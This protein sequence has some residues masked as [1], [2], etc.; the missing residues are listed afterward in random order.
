L[1]RALKLYSSI[2]LNN[3]VLFDATGKIQRYE[4]ALDIIKD[5]AKLRLGVYDKRKNYLVAKL[6]RECE[7]LSAKA[8]FIKLVITGQLII[9]R[10]KILDLVADLRKRGFKPLEDVKGDEAKPDGDN[11]ESDK[12]E[13]DDGEEAEDA[14]DQEQNK[15]KQ[16]AKGIKDFE[17]L[18]G[19][20][21]STLTAEKIE[22]LMRQHDL[23]QAELDALRKKKI[24]RLW[25][26]D[27]DELEQALE[28]REASILEQQRIE[29]ARLA[30][31][32]AKAKTEKEPKRG[33]KRT[34]SNPSAP[35]AKP[36]TEEGTARGQKR[37]Q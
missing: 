30:K 27:L 36:R 2:S 12:E 19:M 4:S 26:D 5:F 6:M 22:E 17:Y 28:E 14:D 35:S 8:R 20:P 13:D 7:V 10:R 21:I 18:V 16:T 1:D 31:A 29:E 3:M 32:K 25:M 24:E 33:V 15:K 23:K 37:R 34:A 9:K 11:E